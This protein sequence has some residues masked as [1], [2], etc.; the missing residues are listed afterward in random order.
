MKTGAK[1]PACVSLTKTISNKIAKL[2]DNRQSQVWVP[3]SKHEPQPLKHAD[4]Q[5]WPLGAQSLP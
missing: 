2:N 3:N 4:G 5:Q 1:H